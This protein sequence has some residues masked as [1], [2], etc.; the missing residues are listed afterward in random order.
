[1]KQ[2]LLLLLLS[3][4]SILAPAHVYAQQNLLNT[5]YKNATTVPDF[6]NICGDADTMIVTVRANNNSAATRE[7][8]QL[9]LTFFEGVE[10]VAL[11]PSSST[12]VQLVDDSDPA[13]LGFTLP[14]L[15]PLGLQQVD[16]ALAVRARCDYID[17]IAQNNIA[18]V[19]DAYEYTY[20][21]SG[22]TFTET[23]NTAEYSDAF[24]VAQLTIEGNSPVQVARLGQCFDRS[25]VVSNAALEGF[26]DSIYY[27]N[28][29]SPGISVTGYTVNGIPV[30]PQKSLVGTDTLLSFYIDS[31]LLTQSVVG[32]APG[33]GD[34][35][36]DP[37]EQVVIV[38]SI[39]VVSCF[40]SRASLHNV[41][42]G[43]DGEF[44]T[45]ETLSNFVSIGNGAPNPTIVR[46]GDILPTSVGYCQQGQEVLTITNNGSES[47]PGFG[48]A[49]DVEVGV[50]L[51]PLFEVSAS[52][53]QIQELVIA[54]Q[55]ITSPDS[56][57][58]LD[59]H[60]QFLFDPDGAG[61]LED[62]DGDGYYDDLPLGASIQVE[63]RFDF[64]C[65]IATGNS[66]DDN[67]ANDIGTALNA[68]MLYTN[69]CD[70]RLVRNLSS[71]VRPTNSRPDFENLSN[72]D[73]D[74]AIDTFQI[75]H[76]QLRSVRNFEKNCN[77]NEQLIVKVALPSG[78]AF[79]PSATRIQ[80]VE[81]F[82]LPLLSSTQSADTLTLV[83]DA[84]VT[85]FIN[86]DYEFI[87]GFTTDCTTQPGP[88]SFGV[89]IA[90]YCPP[91]D[92]LHEWYCGEVSGPQLHAVLPNC[93]PEPP[94]PNGMKATAFTVERTTFG[95]E[96]ASY[97]TPVDPD[98]VRR[99]V[100]LSCDSVQMTVAAIVGDDA[101]SDSIVVRIRYDNI[102]DILSSDEIFAFGEGRVR[103]STAGGEVECNI[104]PTDLTTTA[105]DTT[106]VLEFDLHNCMQTLGITLQPGD[107]VE[108]IGQFAINPDGPY[109]DGFRQVPNFRGDM[110]HVHQGEERSCD[111]YGAAFT[112]SQVSSLF[113]FPSA[114]DFPTGC[115]ARDLNFSVVTRALDYEV[116]FPNEVRPNARVDSIIIDFDTAVY[117]AFQVFDPQVQIP[118]HPVHGDAFFE[119]PDFSDFGDGQYVL[120]FDTLSA[121]PPLSSVTSS[122]FTLRITTQAN[123]GSATASSS[124]DNRFEFD[125][126][127]YYQNKLYAANIGDGSC[128]EM[129]VESVNSDIFYTD[130][131]TFSL[132]PLSNPNVQLAGDTLE[133]ILQNCNTS[134]LSD[135]GLNWVALESNASSLAV[136]AIDDITDPNDVQSLPVVSYGA[137][138]SNYFA[139]TAPLLRAI[140]GN[141]PSDICNTLSIKYVVN[142]CGTFDI[143]ARSGWNCT[144]YDEPDWTPQLYPPCDDETVALSVTTLIPLIDAAVA[145]QPLTSVDFCDTL[146]YTLRVKNADLGNAF[147][148]ASQ[149][150]LP[151][152]GIDLVPGSVE[153]A[154]P[155]NSAFQPVGA[156][157]GF[158]EATPRG[159][160][161][162]IADFSGLSSFLAANGL[163]GFNPVNPSDSSEYRLRF[164]VVTQCGFTS[165]STIGY[166]FQG[167]AGCG[168]TTN[169]A[170]GE[171]L[172]IFINGAE[173]SIDEIFAAQFG[174]GTLLN[175][176]G[177]SQIE[178]IV[179]NLTSQPSDA[180]DFVR[181]T[182]PPGVTYQ[183]GTTTVQQ[184]VGT[185]AQAPTIT[186]E[187]GVQILVWQLPT[188]LAQNDVYNFTF[189]VDLPATL[190]CSTGTVEA[191][192]AV[193]FRVALLCDAISAPCNIDVNSTDGG[194]IL[195]DLPVVEPILTITTDQAVSACNGTG[196]SVTVSGTITD[197]GV[198]FPAVDIDVVYYHDSNS[199]GAIDDTDPVV[200]SFVESGPIGA[201]M[202]LE[203]AHTF[204]ATPEQV[205]ALLVGI[206]TTTTTVCNAPIDVV[207]TPALQNA[208][209]QLTLCEGVTS[210]PVGDA[211]CTG[212]PGYTYQ[213]FALGSASTGSLS[214]TTIP[215]PTY[216]ISHDGTTS[217]TLLYVLQTTRPSCGVSSDTL[218]VVLSE[219]PT[220]SAGPDAIV[221]VGGST[222][223]LPVVSGGVGPYTYV[224]E[225]TTGLDDPDSA[226]PTAAPVS[227]TTYILTVTTAQGCTATDTL[228][229]L[230]GDV[231]ATTPTDS[232]VVCLNESIILQ[233][234]G[235]D[236]YTWFSA[237]GNPTGGE[238]SSASTATP[239]F[240]SSAVG[241]FDYFV[242][243]YNASTPQV[244]D[245]AQVT[246]TVL[247]VPAAS[248][249]VTPASSICP[250]E[251]ITLVAA[252][253]SAYEWQNASSGIS[254][255][256]SAQY[257]AAPPVSTSYLLIATNDSGCTDSLTLDINVGDTPVVDAGADMTICQGDSVSLQGSATGGTPGGYTFS[258]SP[259][260]VS[261]GFT[262]TAVVAPASSTTYTLTATDANG[263]QGTDE[264]TVTVLPNAVSILT[265]ITD[266]TACGA[267][268]T[269]IKLLYSDPIESFTVDGATPVSATVDGDTLLVAVSVEGTYTFS[270][271]N[272]TVG[273]T[274]QAT[275]TV[276]PCPCPDYTVVVLDSEPATCNNADGA[277][278]LFPS[279]Y[280]YSWSDG[281]I[282][283]VRMDIASGFYT[284]TV[285]DPLQPGCE[286]TIDVFV[287][288]DSDLEVTAQGVVTT[289]CSSSDGAATITVTG[290]SGSY[291]YLW[292]D[293]GTGAVRTGLVAQV[294][295]VQVTD[296]VSGCTGSVTID[297]ID[298]DAANATAALLDVAVVDAVCGVSAGSVSYVVTY[299]AA[300]EQP[301][302][303]VI[304]DGVN[305]YTAD[306]LPEGS[307]CITIID[308]QNCIAATSCFEVE[309]INDLVLNGTVTD[310]CP[311]TGAIAI[312]V[313][314]GEAP[315]RYDWADLSADNNA[316]DRTQLTGGTYML[317]V[318]DNNGCST[319]TSY[320]V[321]S[322]DCSPVDI[323][324]IVT[325]NTTC[326]LATGA[327]TVITDPTV[328]SSALSILPN[329][330]TA[331]IVGN[332]IS[333]LPGGTYQVRVQ[334]GGDTSCITTQQVVIQN[335]DG[336][337]VDSIQ[338]LPAT[339]DNTDGSAELTPA[340][341]TYTWP[342]GTVAAN[343]NDLA[344]GTYA[345][346]VSEASSPGCDNFTIVT[347]ESES[348]LQVSAVVSQQ[349][350]CNSADGIVT[351]SAT[352]GSGSYTYVWSDNVTTTDSTRT[353][354]PAGIYNVT[355][356]DSQGCTAEVQLVVIDD[357]VA[358]PTITIGS[359]QSVSCFGES[360]GSIAYTVVASAAFGL[361]L[362]T[363]ITNG[364][365]EYE[366]A[367][368]LPIG[369]YSILLYDADGC[370]VA[371]QSVGVPGPTEAL[372]AV[373]TVS[374]GCDDDGAITLNVSGGTPPF[375]YDWLDLP[376]SDDSTDRTGLSPGS[377]TVVI[378][379]ASGCSIVI[380]SVMIECPT[381]DAAQVTAVLINQATCG[382]ADGAATIQLASTGTQYE[383]SWSPDLGIAS[384]DGATRDFLP[385][386][387]YRVDITN[388]SDT[389][390]VTNTNVLVTNADGPRG[391]LVDV[392]DAD[393]ATNNG[394]ATLAPDSLVYVWPDGVESAVRDDLSS[395][396]YTVIYYAPSDS[397]C[398]N[399]LQV[400]VG[401]NSGLTLSSTIIDKPDC[402]SANGTAS[403]NVAGGS[404]SY[405]FVW[406]NGL[407][408]PTQT[409]LSAGV[410]QVL[411]TDLA[412]GCSDRLVFAIEDDV[413]P[414]T[415]T[416]IDTVHI[417]CA[418]EQDGALLY[419]VSFDGAFSA[420]ADTVIT[421]GLAF[422][423]N[424][425]LPAGSYCLLIYDG[426]GCVAGSTCFDIEE[427]E[428]L[429]AV[430]TITDINCADEPGTISPTIS[431]GTGPFTYDWADLPGSDD[432][433][434]R[435]ALS[436]GSY[437]LTITDANGCS[438]AVSGAAVQDNCPD[439]DLPYD[440]GETTVISNNCDELS[441]IC[442][443]IPFAELSNINVLVDGSPYMNTLDGC[444]LDT[445]LVYNA[446]S[447]LGGFDISSYSMTWTV[448]G[449][450][451]SGTFGSV[452][453]LA[454]LMNQLDPDGNWVVNSGIVIEGGNSSSLYGPI[455]A[456]LVAN[457]NISSNL[458][459]SSSVLINGFSILLD[460]GQHEV[461]VFEISTGCTDTLLVNVACPLDSLV[462]QD[463]I[464]VGDSSVYCIDTN[465]LDL[466]GTIVS[467]ENTCPDASGDHVSFEIDTATLC[468]SY[469]GLEIGVDTACITICDDL[470]NCQT[471]IVIVTVVPDVLP[472]LL[473]DLI[474]DTVFVEVDTVV[475][476]LDTDELPGTVV[477]VENV[478]S[479]LSG[480]FVV[481]EVDPGSYCVTYYGIDVGVDT[482]CFVLTD[483]LGNTDTTSFCIVSIAAQKEIFYDT[484]F[485]FQDLEYC[486]DTSELPGTIIE[487]FN[488]CPD[489]SGES[490]AFEIDSTSLCITYTGLAL[491][492]DTACIVFCDDF[493]YCDT[494]CLI[495]TVEE[496]FDPPTANNDGCDTIL[497]GMPVVLDVLS[498]DTAFGG[499]DSFYLINTP[500]YGEVVFN[501][502]NTI[503]Y[504]PDA[505]RCEVFDDFEYMICTPTG[506]DFATVCV[507]IECDDIVIFNAV[508]PNDDGVNDEFH[509]S[510]IEDY[511]NN[512]LYIY[513]RWGSIVYETTA[514]LNQ[515]KGT[516]LDNKDLPDGTYYYILRLN[517]EE[518]RVYKGYLQ[519]Q[520]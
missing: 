125:P 279:Q 516:T 291:A 324:G 44:C 192:L 500:L 16:I 475:Y 181:V 146:T 143:T 250:G 268:P 384:N 423:P 239:Q 455:Q 117:T 448:D 19:R 6:L 129:V 161:Y 519:I 59:N 58:L 175:P 447:L 466:P 453:E 266:L 407:A 260:V 290:G 374:S 154:Y 213:W 2:L 25:I 150:Y 95:F 15:S 11:L 206:D 164:K 373:A 96:D 405:S 463:E 262:S 29:Q 57:V 495:I 166:G 401:E 434:E 207:P 510:N 204:D 282:G 190:D 358:G 114:D 158:V 427:P 23:D 461:V 138:G 512:E 273:C 8:I 366:T 506:C 7:N 226:Q 269:L 381:C 88:S 105:G 246:V 75:V 357:T 152:S 234:S 425:A 297:L 462:I 503:T 281:G 327:L 264:V 135:A 47:N 72:T 251:L 182:L 456:S 247:P 199:N 312:S 305:Q 236:T 271:S 212:T 13:S 431:G 254:L 445:A 277:I 27:E 504:I 292:S 446:S 67:C 249:S 97:T 300:F 272:A 179:Q 420:P 318:T 37:D 339:C 32:A 225:P 172:P 355:V 508:S 385:L 483:D 165:G 24:A 497:Q 180:Q 127:I 92:C 298:P 195:T 160:L 356:S 316:A 435:T 221:P 265:D 123:C 238:L 294:Y 285:T 349:S 363:V 151:L 227:N 320:V 200:A 424:G 443:D 187:S 342:D 112:I 76:R 111:N 235:G 331:T 501:L 417:S 372:T 163:P 274:A 36:L 378:T 99:D 486:V 51:G 295:L 361:A 340:I 17:T 310:A 432:P 103:F 62:A 121:P 408:G 61:G 399:V 416:P 391:Q 389:T 438:V 502:D 412:T 120:R 319:S 80:R 55:V 313:S 30:I 419:S 403:V 437:D 170:L 66:G 119:V 388:V 414:A 174:P 191:E 511:P 302:D 301:A 259:N 379:D 243:V 79:E 467:I 439:C 40:E 311:G 418:G 230:I 39:C 484:I 454:D 343:R 478:C 183:P 369:T 208:G 270:L 159:A 306:M 77:G 118:N 169:L 115:E 333:G 400:L 393:C 64:D 404:G 328:G 296:Q 364:Q 28:V 472:P 215:D 481:F 217:D 110:Y 477:S 189:D 222:Q 459:A 460:T 280:N 284:V 398:Q 31:A 383:F 194:A 9:T 69:A 198:D 252:G 332:Q 38:E 82:D 308:S 433:A 317:T 130:P 337:Q 485:I 157:F 53:L 276:Q 336:P 321:E 344:P 156:E 392:Q 450:V 359:V 104:L 209:N 48:T 371:A 136:I 91:C 241:V 132:T 232:L 487:I 211:A 205:C 14:D 289:D 214:S 126:T 106:K 505:R 108:F 376:G 56:L 444:G 233:A 498:N 411:V 440:L 65:T 133:Y 224:W 479:N 496:F 52:L 471:V 386:G 54:G 258:W 78:V 176:A 122:A 380:P 4:G 429:T 480:D 197:A 100:A 12:G 491:G 21:V 35:F 476:C 470:G 113:V 141:D 397:G 375:S 451:F 70:Q 5:S 240:S 323:I 102:N 430:L 228:N 422:Y 210:L 275:F 499:L 513:N 101:L 248:A 193:F 153:L 144:A 26:V 509:I 493:G 304:T 283:S 514:Y 338:T 515:W 507:F 474:K 421:D 128:S 223:L 18:L 43:C 469:I 346:T 22:N 315:Y 293:G 145:T 3:A 10:Y 229:V 74:I 309:S 351:I 367:D 33:N 488:D 81:M 84:T 345:V 45:T 402:G 387:S 410:Y 168:D 149:V 452:L 71:F 370:L 368:A 87:I 377:Y 287:S 299:S 60:P 288:E 436:L 341:L 518:D 490:V 196:E 20:T 34:G 352:N 362:D 415:V 441:T 137:T 394:G 1:M 303:T 517:D 89:S 390:C 140:S 457:P 147:D 267:S 85:P 42:F 237:A 465:L 353:N 449:V 201:G 202:L 261:G 109:T 216:T 124:G 148:V 98:S 231:T 107:S 426:N 116:F 278:T 473:P 350:T 63:V 382:N 329:P 134:F 46:G 219:E 348:N 83:F 131:P 244:R 492:Q 186:T 458:T 242:E 322:C 442:I 155:A 413:P 90:H 167:R 263:C 171:T 139:Y 464:M 93:P 255:S 428:A 520:R 406:S 253:G 325:Q 347:I 409:T 203:Y 73:A 482:A 286:A 188:G 335:T 162:E 173:P 49:I 256:T 330:A 468:I 307:Y 489:A 178:V 360:D 50:G 41:A 177:G 326:D 185:S 68:R 354:L 396:L 334:S 94:C 257:T 245:T 365:V 142:S 86:G 314:G 494:A 395:G 218:V 184:P 220:V